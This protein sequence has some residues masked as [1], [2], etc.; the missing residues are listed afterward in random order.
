MLLQE[1]TAEQRA[2]VCLSLGG[3]DGGG[4]RWEKKMVLN[5]HKSIESLVSLK[6]QT[7]HQ[8]VAEFTRCFPTREVAPL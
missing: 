4:G 5:R 3:G 2:S 8:G 1:A 6:K 7:T